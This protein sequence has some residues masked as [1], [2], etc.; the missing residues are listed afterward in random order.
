MH[1]Y[2]SD[3]VIA[4]LMM[5]SQITTHSLFSKHFFFETKNR[6]KIYLAN[7]FVKT[8]CLFKFLK[9][10]YCCL[11]SRNK[12]QFNFKANWWDRY[13]ITIKHSI[14]VIRL[15]FGDVIMCKWSKI[16][17][18]SNIR[19]NFFLILPK[20]TFGRWKIRTPCH[21]LNN[22]KFSTHAQK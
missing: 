12:H 11:N 21:C 6:K 8:L 14:S 22:T 1:K 13:W 7:F 2:L 4:L 9:K 3:D 15:I 10:F 16:S 5:S 18:K 17:S 19:H 20:D